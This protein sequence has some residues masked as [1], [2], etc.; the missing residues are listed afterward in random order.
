M[1]LYVVADRGIFPTDREWLDCLGQVARAIANQPQVSLQVRAKVAAP[2][3]RARLAARARAVL[4]TS[5]GEALLD[6]ALLNGTTAEAIAAG[7]RGAHWPEAAIPIEPD[8][9]AGQLV[10]GASIH[11]I[12]ALVAAEAAGTGFVLFGPVF[13]PRSKA[14]RGVGLEALG[15][16]ASRARVPVIAIGGMT[17]SRVE[18]CLHAGAAGVAVV[19]GVLRA[20]DPARA[21]AEYLTATRNA[22][23]VGTL[24]PSRA[25]QWSS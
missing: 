23:C 22:A 24:S 21:I 15:G 11:S 6:R 9:R 12:A 20:P 4:V 10:V 7:Y 2:A 19:S 1:K 17:P 25:P 18:S 5:G 3:R 14:G 16:V 8:P 13:D